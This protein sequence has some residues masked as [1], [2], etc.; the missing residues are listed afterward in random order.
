MVVRVTVVTE[1]RVV[2]GASKDDQRFWEKNVDQKSNQLK[3]GYKF[4][5]EKSETNTKIDAVSNSQVVTVAIW[6][7]L[8]GN[9]CGLKGRQV[10]SDVILVC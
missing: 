9:D 7:I 5:I 6:L 10:S 2:V 4:W 1:V 8:T 3:I